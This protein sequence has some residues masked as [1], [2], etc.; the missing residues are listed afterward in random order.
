MSIETE[1]VLPDASESNTLAA[2]QYGATSPEASQ[3]DTELAAE[4]E[5][6]R[7]ECSSLRDESESLLMQVSRDF[8]ELSLI[9]SV[10]QYLAVAGCATSPSEIAQALLP[11]LLAIAEAETVLLVVDLD[12][13]SLEAHD[14]H[15]PNDSF[16]WVGHCLLDEQQCRELVATH[17]ESAALRPVVRNNLPSSS[18]LAPGL[19]EFMMIE[20][21]GNERL[22]GW[23]IACNRRY[24]WKEAPSLSEE[25]FTSFQ[26]TLLGSASS[27][28]AVTFHNLDLLRQKEALLTDMIRA[29]VNALDACDP[30][31]C[32]HSE[33]VAMYARRLGTEIGLGQIEIE[34]VYLSGLLHDIGRMSVPDAILQKPGH[35]TEEEFATIAKHPEWAWAVLHESEAL[36]HE[37]PGVLHH[38]ERFDGTGYPDR[39][40]GDEIPLDGR[41]IAVCDAYDAM[42]SDRP[43]RQ[44]MPQEKVESILRDGASSQWDARLVTAFLSAMPDIIAIRRQHRPRGS[45]DRIQRSHAAD[46]QE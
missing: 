3:Q 44:R 10:V 43:Y 27:M 9:R 46:R 17:R 38:H 23:L 34:R 16:H 1:P 40:A 30:Y 41:I 26:A 18:E 29:I 28:L 7:R 12:E 8:E 32:G 20:I 21:R 13:S 42:T 25:G 11:E 24:G 19:R 14:M 2:A 39:L 31:M 4:V 15:R 5:E 45:G 37:L 6:L 22:Y 35:L 36:R 33:R